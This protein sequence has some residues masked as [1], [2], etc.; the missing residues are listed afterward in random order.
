MICQYDRISIWHAF[1]IEYCVLLK[2]LDK[3][4]NNNKIYYYDY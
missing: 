3:L 1:R 2:T 4:K